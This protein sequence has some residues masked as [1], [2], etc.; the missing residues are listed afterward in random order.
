[1]DDVEGFWL[2]GGIFGVFAMEASRPRGRPAKA[3]GAVSLLSRG[4]IVE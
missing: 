3:R 1:M 4:E 2:G